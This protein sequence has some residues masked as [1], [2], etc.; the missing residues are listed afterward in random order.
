MNWCLH[1]GQVQKLTIIWRSFQI[2]ESN[3]TNSPTSRFAESHTSN[4]VKRQ[5]K[6]TCIIRK[7]TD[8]WNSFRS[9]PAT[10]G[11]TT[12]SPRL[13]TLTD[14]DGNV[15]QIRTTNHQ[16]TDH[17]FGNI[18]IRPTRIEKVLPPQPIESKPH[19]LFPQ[20]HTASRIQTRK[21]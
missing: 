1:N 19:G 21:H 9:N 10:V 6:T 3:C 15:L 16:R 18:R 17:R 8:N 4:I 5:L 20:L 11:T 12:C 13:Q 14:N 2:V 7:I